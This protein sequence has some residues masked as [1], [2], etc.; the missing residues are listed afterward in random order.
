G[1]DEQ[2]V[3]RMVRMSSYR[4]REE[5][6]W[7][8]ASGLPA[9]S[10][11]LEEYLGKKM[12]QG[13]GVRRCL[14]CHTTNPRAILREAGPEAADHS[15]GCE[16]CHSPAGHHIAAVAA[17]FSDLAIDRPGEASPAELDQICAKCHGNRQP[18][19]VGLPRTDPIWLRFQ[20]LTLTWSRCYTES[21]G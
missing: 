10:A 19:R 6:G 16:K 8:L 17:R 4:Y 9:R 5:K 2:G 7:D 15:I 21:D 13:D 11:D 12:L 1:H 3:P 14:N 18:E 20:S